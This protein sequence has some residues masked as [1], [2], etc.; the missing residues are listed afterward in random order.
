M[1]R[2]RR[3][4]G[5]GYEDHV[6]PPAT[7]AF[8]EASLAAFLG[9]T[10][11]R[12]TPPRLKDIAIAPPRIA[13][14]STLANRASTEPEERLGHAMGKSS[15]DVARAIRGR[16]PNVPDFVAYPEDEAD[17]ARWLDFAASNAVAVVPYGGGSSVA[18]GVEPDVGDAYR[19]A[20]SLDLGR[21]NRVLEVDTVSLTA[22]IQGGA[23]GPALEAELKPHGL[24]LRHYPQSFECS[25]LGGWI[26]TRAGG[27]YATLA[28]HV[29][30]LVESLRVVTPTG[31]VATRRLPASGAGP[32]PERFFI[33]SE[34]ALGVITEAW[35]RVV[36]RPTYRASATAR[37]TD[38]AKGA[39]ALRAIAQSGLYPTNARLLDPAEAMV[40]GSGRGDAALLLLAFESSDH[41]LEPWI[42]RAVTVARDYG[43]EVAEEKVRFAHEAS[44]ARDETADTYKKL[45]LEAPYLRDEL[46]LRGVF[47][48]TYETAVTWAMLPALDAAVRA[49]VARLA[50]GP[51]LL[52]TRITHAY[53]DGAAPYYTLIL[54]A[55]DDD[56]DGQWF[57]AKEAITSAIIDA[58][59]TS[60]HHHAV[61]RDVV[62]YYERE[63]DPLFGKVL[64]AVKSTLDPSAIMNPGVLLRAPSAGAKAGR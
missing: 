25:S 60:T 11:A 4:W 28:T 63:R 40:S 27:H 34:G 55:D 51:H 35:M 13:P 59:G 3:F 33:G 30:D 41:E 26:A 43:G 12:R 8:A 64:G 19:G 50:K 14:P 17:V 21:M 38:F 44:G 58:G 16:F 36:V 54:P 47:V 42:R 29:D 39:E 45:F 15:R 24:S 2:A 61:G 9:R 53:P 52:A 20:I 10:P 22:R 46:I 37:F 7:L 1:P 48:E 57:G 5:W 62:P 18:G 49:A 6:V 23:L 31:L 56:P 32:S